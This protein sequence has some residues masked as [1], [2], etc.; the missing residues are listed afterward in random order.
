MFAGPRIVCTMASKWQRMEDD[1]EVFYYN[2]E[3]GESR[4]SKPGWSKVTD[5]DGDT[6]QSLWTSLACVSLCLS[7]RPLLTLN[8]HPSSTTMT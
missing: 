7:L 6:V 5:E 8:V 4:W 3:T 1:G 2:E